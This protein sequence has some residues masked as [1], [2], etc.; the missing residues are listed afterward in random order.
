MLEALRKRK[1]TVNTSDDLAAYEQRRV[2]YMNQTGGVLTGYDC[3]ECRNKGIVYYLN[4][5]GYLCHRECDCM[6]TRRALQRIEKSGLKQT[7]DSQT[8]ESF[9]VTQPFQRRAKALGK[10]FLD[11]CY[12]KWFFFGGQVGCG[13][14]HL[15]TAIVGEFIKRGYDARYMLWRDDVVRIKANANSDDYN[16][17][18]DPFKKAKVLY[19]DDFFKTEQGKKPSTAE[20]N[21]AF[22]LLNYRYNDRD[23]ITLI[24]CER[25]TNALL[26]IDEAVGSRIYQRSKEYCLCIAPDAN[27]N[28]R[29]L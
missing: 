4:K 3:Q 29:L 7:L 17:L 8:F 2:D 9:D 18:L 13:K 24:S 12:G 16:V 26:D 1:N 14:T 25:D 19:I 20:I 27:K 15:C 22:E 6:G 23:L 5:D 10:Q 28:Y 21:V 11:D